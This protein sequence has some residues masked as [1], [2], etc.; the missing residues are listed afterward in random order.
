MS[1]VLSHSGIILIPPG[2]PL[3]EG[4]NCKDLLGKS[5]FEKGGFENLQGEG[6]YGKRY[7]YQKTYET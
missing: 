2:P 3:E 7:N 4:G 5:P 6:N 1:N